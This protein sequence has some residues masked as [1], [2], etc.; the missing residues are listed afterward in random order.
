MGKEMSKNKQLFLF[1]SIFLIFVFTSAFA[2]AEITAQALDTVIRENN[3]NLKTA[4]TNILNANKEEIKNT[5]ISGDFK[6]FVSNSVQ[7]IF[8]VERVKTMIGIF[9]A[10]LLAM[11]VNSLIRFKLDIKKENLRK[12]NKEMQSKE[13]IKPQ[14]ILAREQEF[15]KPEII[16]NKEIVTEIID[17]NKII[18]VE[19]VKE[20]IE[21]HSTEN[22]KNKIEK[23]KPQLGKGVEA[24]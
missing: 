20:Q 5:I 15:P 23:S 11:L 21:K 18:P 17:D 1:A 3:E 6:Q 22:Y 19:Q 12:V 14:E 9:F 10:V 24:Y 2:R 8:Q 13:Q 7:S 16:E 4:I